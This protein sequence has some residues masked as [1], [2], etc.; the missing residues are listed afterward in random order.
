[1]S[2]SIQQQKQDLSTLNQDYATKYGFHD[3]VD[4]FHKGAKGLSHE[5]VEMISQMKKEPE[6]MTEIRHEALDIFLCEA[7]AQMGQHRTARRNRFRQYLLLHE[8]DR[9]PADEL[10]RCPGIYQ[11]D[12]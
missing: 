6:W 8:A 5:V 11:E 12:V 10:G 3:P 1:M 9:K 2:D 7:D 4:Y